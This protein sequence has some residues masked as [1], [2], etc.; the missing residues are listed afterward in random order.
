MSCKTP[1]KTTN[2]DEIYQWSYSKIDSIVMSKSVNMIGSDFYDKINIYRKNQLI[3]EYN[4]T[5]YEIMGYQ[6]KLMT[7]FNS[8]ELKMNFYIFE[9]FNAPGPSKYLII[10]TNRDTTINLGITASSSAEIFGDIDYDGVFE[11]GGLEDYCRPDSENPCH[12]IDYYN[13]FEVKSGFPID[14]SLTA[15]IK[16]RYLS[17]KN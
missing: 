7:Q 3:Y 17:N 9:L 8:N 15:I 5:N 2:Q 13:V 11:I 1:M 4:E 14:T 12:P 6:K 10:S 16:N